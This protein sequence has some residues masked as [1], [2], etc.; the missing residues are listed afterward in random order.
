M[1]GDTVG[2]RV[3][4]VTEDDTDGV[5]DTTY[6]NCTVG[7]VCF[8]VQYNNVATGK[9]TTEQG[10]VSADDCETKEE[11]FEKNDKVKDVK[12]VSTECSSRK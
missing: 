4:T 3:G 1:V 9:F 6:V 7:E 10:C 12:N 11:S 2:C 5:G 8:S